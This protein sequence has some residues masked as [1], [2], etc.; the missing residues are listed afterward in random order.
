LYR[1]ATIFGGYESAIIN[2]PSV[3]LLNLKGMT[4]GK[5]YGLLEASEKHEGAG[6]EIRAARRRTL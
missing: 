5:R 1:E 4:E 3:P 2:P 6:G